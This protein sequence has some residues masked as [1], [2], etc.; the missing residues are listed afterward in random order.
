[1]SRGKKKMAQ[2]ERKKGPSKGEKRKPASGHGQEKSQGSHR[3]GRASF[4]CGEE[5]KRNPGVDSSWCGISLP[6]RDKKE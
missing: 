3:G 1:M 2:K 4:D 5:G 6:R